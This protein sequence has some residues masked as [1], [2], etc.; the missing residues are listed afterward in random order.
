MPASVT[1][2][3]VARSSPAHR[4]SSVVLPLPE[5]P[6]MAS[7]SPWVRTKLTPFKTVRPGP[8]CGPGYVLVRSRTSRAGV[9]SLIGRE[10]ETGG[11]A[12]QTF[13]PAS[14]NPRMRAPVR[15]VGSADAMEQMP[16]DARG[17]TGLARITGRGRA[18]D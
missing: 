11:G 2:P 8:P 13:S 4:P 1:D 15:C 18:A 10:G 6:T 5:G 9:L 16:D 12:P 17:R 3:E 14:A 7:E